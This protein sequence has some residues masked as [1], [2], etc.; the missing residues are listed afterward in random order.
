[1]ERFAG[2]RGI[3]AEHPLTFDGSTIIEAA[4]EGRLH[5]VHV[6]FDPGDRDVLIEAFR[7]RTPIRMEGELVSEGNRLK[8]NNPRGLTTVPVELDQPDNS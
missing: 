1:M 7:N 3:W 6:Q 4:V 5:R 2:Y 8:L